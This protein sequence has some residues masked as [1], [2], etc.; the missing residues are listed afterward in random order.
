VA[1]L[2][3][4]G[5][6]QIY[7][8][9]GSAAVVDAADAGIFALEG[10]AILV[11]DG[12]IRR[13]GSLAEVSADLPPDTDIHDMG[14]RV[15]IPC[16]VDPHTHVVWGGNRSDEFNQRLH[17]AASPADLYTKGWRTLDQMLLHGIGTIEAKSGY[18][19][20]PATELKQLDVMDALA[21][22][23]PVDLVQTFMGAHEVPVEFAGRPG[24][25]VDMLNDRLLPEVA[26]RGHRQRQG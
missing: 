24:D 5:L 12:L 13:L 9:R 19:L 23:H 6:N 17:G 7:S 11:E 26:A 16:F 20:E 1:A 8:A 2:L 21:A 4:K 14:G 10:G 25:Y 18:G 22:N 3:L 15:A